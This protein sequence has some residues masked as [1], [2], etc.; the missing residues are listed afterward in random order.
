MQDCISPQTAV[1]QPS[2]LILAGVR[3]A[4]VCCFPVIAGKREKKNDA[5]AKAS[6]CSSRTW[7]L[8]LSLCW[9]QD[10]RVLPAGKRLTF[11]SISMKPGKA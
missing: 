3:N 5:A 7:M 2:L 8:W 10:S 6:M 1:M 9:E 4:A 11:D